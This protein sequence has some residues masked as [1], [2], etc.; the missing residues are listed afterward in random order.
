MK[1]TRNIFTRFTAMI[2]VIVSLLGLFT[3][4]QA[5][6]DKSSMSITVKGRSITVTT[7]DISHKS[8]GTKTCGGNKLA[9]GVKGHTC[10]WEYARLEYKKIWGT[11]FSRSNG[12]NLLRDIPAKERKVT[13]ANLDYFFSNAKPG[14]MLRVDKD[15]VA[16]NGDNNGHSMIFL[17]KEGSGG[18]FWEGNYD[19]KGHVR[20]HYWSWSSL[21]SQ[22]GGKYPYVKYIIYPGAIAIK[23]TPKLSISGEKYPSG[24]LSKGKSFGLRGEY[25]GQGGVTISEVTAVVMNSLYMP[26]KGFSFTCKLNGATYFNTNGTKGS[27]GKTLNNTFCFNKLPAGTYTFLLTIKTNQSKMD[28]TVK[29]TFTIK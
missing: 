12:I 24:T 14:A 19:N 25:T 10:C 18:W 17:K 5:A 28:H 20:I 26:V 6:S 16:T 22:Y 7:S 13:A 8:T 15:S 3:S 2:L 1:S 9:V 29:K 4:A 23:P 27:N 21:V 11:S